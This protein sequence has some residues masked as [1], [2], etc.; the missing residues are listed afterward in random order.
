MWGAKTSAVL[1]RALYY[2]ELS[3]LA[4]CMAV[5][6][7]PNMSLDY[8]TVDD[9]DVANRYQYSPSL[10]LPSYTLGYVLFPKCLSC[11]SN[12]CSR[13]SFHVVHLL[14]AA[15]VC[16]AMSALLYSTLDMI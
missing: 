11:A 15:P 14:Y 8:R 5:T 6:A 12:L 2:A 13:S 4:L 1:P 16:Y 3:L 9:T 10:I 7:E